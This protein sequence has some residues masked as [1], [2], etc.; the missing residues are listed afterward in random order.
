MTKKC[1]GNICHD[2]ARECVR[3]ARV[4]DDPDLRHE[5]FVIARQWMALAIEEEDRHQNARTSLSAAA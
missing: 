1:S 3:L 5:L 2:L 4:T